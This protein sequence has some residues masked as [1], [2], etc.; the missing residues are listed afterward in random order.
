MPQGLPSLEWPLTETLIGAKGPTEAQMYPI[1]KLFSGI[2]LL[3]P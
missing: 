2:L 1:S 3:T